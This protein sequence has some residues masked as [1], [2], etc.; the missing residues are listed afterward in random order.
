VKSDNGGLFENSVY[1]SVQQDFIEFKGGNDKKTPDPIAALRRRFGICPFSVL[2]ARHWQPRKRQWVKFMG[3]EFGLGGIRSEEGRESIETAQNIVSEKWTPGSGTRAVIDE[4]FHKNNPH[5]VDGHGLSESQ[6]RLDKFMAKPPVP[7]QGQH[8]SDNAIRE[9]INVYADRRKAA[10]RAELPGER[11]Y[12]IAGEQNKD[13]SEED[14]RALG[15]YF[16]PGGSTVGRGMAGGHS[17]GQFSDSSNRIAGGY[18]EEDGT[19]KGITG[20]SVF[21]PVLCECVYRWF[22]PKNGGH[23]LD[24]FAGGSIRGLVAAMLGHKYT[25]IEFRP[26]QVEANRQQAEYI[27]QY[28]RDLRGNPLHTPKWIV[29]DSFELLDILAADEEEAFETYDMVFACPPYYNLEVYSV[30]QKDGSAFE[31]YEK[32]LVWYHKIFEMAISRLKENRF[33][34]IVVG[35]IRDENGIYRNF[36]ADTIKVF[37]DLGLKFYNRAVLVTAVGSLPVRIASQFPKYRKLGNTHQM[38]YVFYKGDNPKAIIEELGLLDGSE[39]GSEND[40]IENFGVEARETI[41]V[42]DLMDEVT[43]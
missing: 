2:D 36:E 42:N 22:L 35:E 38:L 1:D 19:P 12:T 20:T 15:A 29:G 16:A 41:G 23:V 30:D 17:V 9:N 7:G 3:Y 34:A 21:D 13:L 33:V 39:Y 40:M 6:E 14:Q 31:S 5:R 24:P 26:G 37:R 4:D 25:G 28:G 18:H 10:K 27:K 8:H 11:G 32:F 43:E